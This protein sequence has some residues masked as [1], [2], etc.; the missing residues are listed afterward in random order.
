MKNKRS[1]ERRQAHQPVFAKEDSAT[2]QN[3]QIFSEN[4][5]PEKNLGDRRLRE[6]V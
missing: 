1:L 2:S 3:T 4:I 6:G 5:P